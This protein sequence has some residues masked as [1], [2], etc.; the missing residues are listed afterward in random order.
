[1]ADI[2]IIADDLTGALDAAAPFAARGAVTRVV[3]SLPGLATL[4]ESPPPEVVAITT[5]SR[6]LSASAA[7]ERVSEAIHAAQAL[8]PE[9]WIKKVDST[10]R[11]QVIAECL[12]ARRCLDRALLVAPAVPAQGRTTHR[13]RVFVH[14]EP[15]ETT[16]YATD[17]CSPAQGGDL[18]AL[19]GRGGVSMSCRADPGVPTAETDCIVD[20]AD[21]GSLDAVAATLLAATDCWL[22]VGAAGLTGAVAQRRYGEPIERPPLPVN[23]LVL[24]IGSRSPQAQ[25]QIHRCRTS[26]PELPVVSALESDATLPR[27]NVLLIPGQSSESW[28]AHGVAARMAEVLITSDSGDSSPGRA[29]CLSGGDTAMAV[30]VRYGASRIDV[31]GE[32]APGMV[33]GYLDGARPIVTKAG[34]FGDDE[35]LVALYRYTTKV[36]GL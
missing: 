6:H 28:S 1:M 24:A 20:A 13:G 33:C 31:V 18:V 30:M 5:E 7:A 14:D 32:W 21:A 2:V 4:G 16:A 9:L 10:L 35:A 23:G 26:C 11:G 17:A 15:L 22:A 19:F 12:A 8:A 3:T 34:G 29:W 25:Q 27:G 36:E